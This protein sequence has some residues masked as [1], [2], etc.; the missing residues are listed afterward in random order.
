MTKTNA[1][2][3]FWFPVKL[4]K[5][6]ERYFHSVEIS[7]RVRI[8]NPVLVIILLLCDWITTLEI[9]VSIKSNWKLGHLVACLC[10]VQLMHI[11]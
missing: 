2:T 6:I 1:R 4:V 10:I 7:C 11:V 5:V 8:Y 3:D 9:L